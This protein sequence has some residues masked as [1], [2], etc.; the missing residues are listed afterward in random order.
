MVVAEF[1]KITILRIRRPVDQNINS[2]MQWLSNSLGLVGLRDK[3]KSCYRVFIELLKAA[4]KGQSLSSDEI[5]YHLGLSRGTVVH[6]LNKLMA[7]GIVAHD[8][9]KYSLRV[10]DLKQLVR[11]LREDLN[12]SL[13]EIEEIATEIDRQL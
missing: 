11:N 2:E 4:K 13:A 6:H 7:A 8:N 5:S 3:S 1:R 9:N 12:T 10:K